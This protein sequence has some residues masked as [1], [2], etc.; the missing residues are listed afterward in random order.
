MAAVTFS[1]IIVLSIFTKRELTRQI[2][3]LDKE[4]EEERLSAI[5]ENSERTNE[6]QNAV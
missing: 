2:E 1:G 5:S 3:M 6:M 4:E